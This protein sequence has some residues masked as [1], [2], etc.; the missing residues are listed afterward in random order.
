M[1]RNKFKA[2]CVKYIAD[3]SRQHF[4]SLCFP[5]AVLLNPSFQKSRAWLKTRDEK[6]FISDSCIRSLKVDRFTLV[7]FRRAGNA[8]KTNP[9]P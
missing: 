8:L 9:R 1:N 6:Y 5:V 3:S 2:L 7:P 4:K